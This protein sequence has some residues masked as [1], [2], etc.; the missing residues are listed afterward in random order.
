MRIL[1]LDVG[2]KNIGVAVSDPLGITAQGIGVIKRE[3]KQK[4]LL[5]IKNF[6]EKYDVQEILLGYPVNMNGTVGEKAREI[7]NF[8][9]LL[10]KNF[11]IPVSLWDERLS[12]SAVNKT[13]IEADVS[14]SARKKVV[15][16]LAA[17]Y[18]LSSYLQSKNMENR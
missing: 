3:N 4:D 17:V 2:E 12:T 16:K 8:K 7:N 13:L 10:N 6:I 5:Q 11:T 9:K 18:I 14:R 1:C 15:D